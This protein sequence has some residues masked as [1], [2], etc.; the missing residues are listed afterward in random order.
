MDL[1]RVL[2]GSACLA[3]VRSVAANE[4]AT[5]KTVGEPEIV[6]K[7]EEGTP[8]NVAVSHDGRLFLSFPRWSDG[9]PFTVAEVREG[10][11]VPFPNA[12]WNA[13]KPG[14]AEKVIFSAQ[15]VVVDPIN[16][17]W[18][19]DTGS[20]KFGPAVNSPKLVGINLNTNE[21]ERVIPI[22]PDVALEKSYLN[23]V[24]F[25]LRQGKSGFAYMTDSTA[26][27]PNAIIVVDL[28]SGKSWRRLSGHPSVRPDPNFLP[29]IE[30]QAAFQI[31]DADGKVT[32]TR[33]VGAD[34]IAIGADGSRLYYSPLSSRH[35]FSVST[36][37]LRDLSL[38]DAAVAKTVIDHGEKGA[39]DG[40]ESDAEGRVYVTDYEHNAVRR[41]PAGGPYETLVHGPTLL[42]PDALSLGTDGALYMTVNQLH[43]QA[44]FHRGEDQRVKPY[45]IYRI[46]TDGSPV[47]LRPEG[48]S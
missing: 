30:G 31:F 33:R 24:R 25:D 38:D 18:A 27:G 45:I 37:A 15:A 48:V 7:I 20:E 2:V 28:G 44:G 5:E 40:L 4:V 22:P 32:G 11:V 3:L 9:A 13:Y 8:T 41:G 34:G 47:L 35:L 26:A 36:E 6:A 14:D 46:K 16:R 17:L 39:S 12:Q 10:K 21:V 1:L 42:W 43:R 19:L 29:V 23:D